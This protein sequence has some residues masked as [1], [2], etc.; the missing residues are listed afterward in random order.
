MKGKK[1]PRICKHVASLLQFYA[2]FNEKK[3]EL[4]YNVLIKGKRN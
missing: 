2:H 4:F 3:V 1:I